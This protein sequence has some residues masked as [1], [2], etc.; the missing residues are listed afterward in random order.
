MTITYRESFATE[1][2]SATDIAVS[3]YE[4]EMNTTIILTVAADYGRTS[5]QA[6]ITVEDAKNLIGLLTKSLNEVEQ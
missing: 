4:D 6:H 3:R 1:K 5:S 2:S